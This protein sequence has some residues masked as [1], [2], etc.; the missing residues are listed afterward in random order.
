MFDEVARSVKQRFD[1]QRR[2]L[3][4][5]E[6][7]KLFSSHPEHYARDSATYLRDCFD[8]F[9]S[10]KV[11]HFNGTHLRYRLFD[12]VG[13]TQD[14]LVGHEPVQQAIYSALSTFVREGRPNR[15][16][17]L[18]GPNGS[19][20]STLITCIMNALEAYSEVDEGACYRFSW[21]FPRGNDS[22]SIGFES[23]VDAL[24]PG[25]SFAHLPESRIDAKLQSELR[26]HP[27]MLLPF[28]ERRELLSESFRRHGIKR[29]PPRWVERGLLGQKN[30]KI[31]EALLNAYRGD[32]QKVLAHVQVE[33]F[34][35]S[36]RY[37]A[38]LVTIGPE[39][40]VDASERQLTAD[41]SLGSLPASLSALSLFEPYGPLVDGSSGIIEYS[42]LLKRPLDAWRYLLLAIESGEISLPLSTIPL[43]SVLFATTNELHLEA[44]RSHHDY[45]S[46]R[47]RIAPIRMPYLLDYKKEQQIYDTYIVPQLSRPAAPHATF[48]AALWSTL[49]RLSPLLSDAFE[50]E[51]IGRLASMLTPIEKAE[52]YADG[53]VPEHLGGG[54]VVSL[55]AAREEIEDA[56]AARDDYEGVTGASPR[57]IRGLLLVAAQE[58][59]AEELTP[60]GVIL[61]LERLCE[62]SDHAFLKRAHEGGYYNA[63]AFVS[64]VRQRWLD[65]VDEELRV[66]TGFVEESR[67]AELFDRYV[68]HVSYWVKN[69]RV[70]NAMTGDDE[71]ADL[72]LMEQV[73][74]TL[75]VKDAAEHF[76]KDLISTVAGHALDHPDQPVDYAM[77]FPRHLAR[78][79]QSYFAEHRGRLAK[80]ASHLLDRL[81]GQEAGK[82]REQGEQQQVEQA[83]RTFQHKFGYS[84]AALREAVGALVSARYHN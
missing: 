55:L 61:Q 34:Y 29:S 64:V 83:Y 50:D 24:R 7:L 9:G 72:D 13:G 62:T 45:R 70:A 44:F 18:H 3:S 82:R 71:A 54:D 48:V 81:S 43:N 41:R 31:F 16:I 5:G 21:I 74:S 84:D 37:R 53:R 57:E 79:R 2:V 4:F 60:L 80:V 32:L 40:A 19:A 26:E 59:D 56:S 14:V 1:A 6:Y 51:T 11:S 8:H 10:Y 75:D 76:R 63:E 65:R 20:K 42:D 30:K 38:G 47:G 52:L 12:G 67:Y 23:A 39:M 73:E 77:L 33:R 36:R 35:H 78:V 15:L 58:S 22:T 46:F 17:L 68:R 49:T 25:E 66:A 69:E 27:L 28:E